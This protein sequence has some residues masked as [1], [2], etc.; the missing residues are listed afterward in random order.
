[1][2]TPKKM[3]VNSQGLDRGPRKLQTYRANRRNEAREEGTLNMWRY[4][5]RTRS[6]VGAVWVLGS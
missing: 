2:T 5:K 1:M 6:H 4:R 3:E